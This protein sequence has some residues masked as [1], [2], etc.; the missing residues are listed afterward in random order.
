MSATSNSDS[1]N[2]NAKYFNG[3]GQ[4]KKANN[5]NNKPNHHKNNNKNNNNRNNNTNASSNNVAPLRQQ[6]F[7]SGIF[8]L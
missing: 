3:D 6:N 8:I 4:N 2:N 1:A 5:V 7:N